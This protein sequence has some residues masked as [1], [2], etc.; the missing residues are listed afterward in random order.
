MA[1]SANITAIIAC[2]LWAG[3]FLLGRDGTY[4]IYEQGPGIHPNAGQID[5]Y[6]VFPLAVA[7]LLTTS[8]W[9]TN[10]LQR[11]FTALGVIA[12][13]SLFALLPYLL[14]YTGGV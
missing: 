4:D 14:A 3:I 8:A 2:A 5:F 7:L 10:M 13:I 12:A 6:M 9:I 1:R 11:W